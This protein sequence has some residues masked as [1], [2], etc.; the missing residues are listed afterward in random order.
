MADSSYSYTAVISNLGVSSRR[1]TVQYSRD[2]SDDTRPSVY[3][4]IALA[5]T[6]FNDSDI[7][8]KIKEIGRSVGA[9]WYN[10]A[11]YIS[12]NADVNADSFI[13][14]SF[15]F[16]YKPST[17]DSVPEFNSLTQYLTSYESEG[18]TEIR[19][20][21]TV[22][23]LDSAQKESVYS[24]VSIDK[25]AMW[26]KLRNAGHLTKVLRGLG[27]GDDVNASWDGSAGAG[28]TWGAGQINSYGVD[29]VSREAE[30]TYRVHF[31][32]PYPDSNYTVSTGVGAENYSGTGASP[33]QLTVTARTPDYV[34]V[35]CE[36]T[37]DAV[38]EDNAYMSVQV[39]NAQDWDQNEIEF[40]HGDI[41]TVGD[42]LM[43]EVQTILSLNDS[44]F[45]D[46]VQN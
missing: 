15:S 40:I 37:D 22:E 21:Y 29:S 44:D 7:A 16:T 9:Q 34:E 42:S 3:R 46:L 27:G 18:P 38:D 32:Y 1:M 20:K 17:T 2:D 23:D 36:R 13:G 45:L 11:S 43:D 6:E 25:S 19:T 12:A 10:D 31:A 4:T 24:Q 14:D 28:Y 8:A 30:G 26:Q 33:R 35:H 41:F 39:S 5:Q